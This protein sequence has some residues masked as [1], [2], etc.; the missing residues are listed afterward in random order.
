MATMSDAFSRRVF[1]VV[2]RIPPGRVATYGLV[3][4]LVGRPLAA[5]AVGNV[6]RHCEDDGVPCHRVIHATGRPAFPR[7]ATRLR[8]EGVRF[9]DARVDLTRHLWRPRL[10]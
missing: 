4:V 5:R 1:V 9:S 2:R 10:P 6:M 3:A 8:R 7:H